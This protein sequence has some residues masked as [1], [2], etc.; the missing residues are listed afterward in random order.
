MDKEQELKSKAD[1]LYSVP[2]VIWSNA[3]PTQLNRVV[4]IT[5]LT[6]EMLSPLGYVKRRGKDDYVRF[7]REF[8][9]EKLK[10]TFFPLRQLDQE[11]LLSEIKFILNEI[12]EVE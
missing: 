11:L 4:A 10:H 9:R 5:E 7:D 8:F 6:P 1:K 12:S 3:Y 2:P